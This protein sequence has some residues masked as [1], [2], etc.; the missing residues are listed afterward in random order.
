MAAEAK[1]TVTETSVEEATVAQLFDFMGR[2]RPDMKTASYA[3]EHASLSIS[4][5]LKQVQTT[6][7]NAHAATR[8]NVRLAVYEF[9][10]PFTTRQLRNG[11]VNGREYLFVTKNQFEQLVTD[12]R[13]LE[14]GVRDKNCYGT[15]KLLQK[16]LAMS[17]QIQMAPKPLRSRRPTMVEAV[18][19]GPKEASLGQLLEHTGIDVQA[20]GDKTPS[21][22]LNSVDPNHQ[23]LAE[24]RTK[25][26]SAIYDI[27]VPLT[28]RS[29]R[30]GETHGVEYNFVS[31][32]EFMH[33]IQEDQLLERGER[34]GILY[35][36]MKV[37]EVEVEKLK[38][39]FQTQDADAAEATQ[40]TSQEPAPKAVE[41][42]EEIWSESAI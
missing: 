18:K 29:P 13:L 39:H 20:G 7:D 19:A 10:T 28:T 37:S 2:V 15:P 30:E 16:N 25:I 33:Y 22:F 24:V 36:T 12:N 41:G 3:P 21:E 40:E 38:E 23:Q 17:Q 27:T 32:E 4:Q 8:D 14:W 11:E 42:G 5:F 34:N 1:T 26:K 6:T 31:R 35:G 9:T